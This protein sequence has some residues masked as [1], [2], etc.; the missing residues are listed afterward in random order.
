MD[1]NKFWQGTVYGGRDYEEPEY[2]C[3]CCKEYV[4]DPKDV[5][6]C[7]KCEEKLKEE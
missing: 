7:C 4:K 3:D 6:L 2:Q 5:L 1:L